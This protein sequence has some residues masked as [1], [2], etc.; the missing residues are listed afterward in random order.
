M[1][2]SAADLRRFFPGRAEPEGGGPP[3]IEIDGLGPEAWEQALREAAPGAIVTGWDTP[4]LPR[5]WILE[6]SCPLRYVCHVGGSVR[7]LVPREFIERGGRVSN[8]GAL[9]APMVAEHALLLVLAGLRNAGLWRT[10][11][12]T[13]SADH[14]EA[15]AARSLFGRR[16]GI[17]GF[18]AVARA[19]VPL[20]RPFRASVA[21]FS[22]GVP[23]DQMA[24]MGVTPAGSLRELF[25]T[26]QVLVECEALT[27]RNEAVVSAELIGAMPPGALFV[28]VGRG[29][30]VDEAALADAARQGRIRVALDVVAREPLG[31]GCE[32]LSVRG[33]I[34][35]P[36]IAGPTPDHYAEIGRAALDNL[37]RHL[38]GE[39]VQNAVDLAV[40]DRST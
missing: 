9:A 13:A 38:K 24:A 14:K 26:C 28:N 22:E 8:W 15:V 21:A 11:I 34:L 4:P 23:P 10:V 2:L 32:L 29:R 17:H 1:A 7:R 30:I 12:G 37:A 19:L 33:A 18:G 40:Y 27:D 31:S 39:P 35:S 20:L 3:R 36:H 16:V 5:S 6:P 25:S